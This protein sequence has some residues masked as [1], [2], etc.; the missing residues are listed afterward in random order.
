MDGDGLCDT[1]WA[2]VLRGSGMFEVGEQEMQRWD[3]Y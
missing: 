3:F 2:L 1:G